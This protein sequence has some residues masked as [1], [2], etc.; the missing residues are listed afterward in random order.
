ME[1]SV[2]LPLLIPY[3]ILEMGLRIFAIVQ[4]VNTEKK[5]IRLRFDSM[6]LWILVVAL[7][8]FGWAAYFIFGKVEE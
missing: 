4:I 6:I 8:N 3:L 5:G 2:L 1:M 7:V